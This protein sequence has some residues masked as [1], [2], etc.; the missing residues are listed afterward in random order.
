MADL[1]AKLEQAV[2]AVDTRRSGGRISSISGL[3]VRAELPL[4]RV[5]ELCELYEPGK[6]TIGFAEVVGIDGDVALLSLHGE[7]RGLSMR[8]EVVPSGREPSIEV[9][10]FLIGAII[11]AHGHIVRR[12]FGTS[13]LSSRSFRSLYGS[14]VDPL[15]RK[16]ISRTFVTGV[17][18]IDAML[19]CGEGQRVGIFGPPGAGKSTLISEIIQ[20]TQADVIVC[21]LVGER[22][23][24]VGEF[25]QH[26]MPDAQPSKMVLVSATSDRP[27]L[28]RYKAVL[29]ATAI[30]E[31]FRD[32]GK[33]VL[34]VID[35]VTRVARAMREIGL[36]SGEPPVRRGFPPSVFAALPQIFERTG[37]GVSGSITAFY[38]VLVEGADN[39]DPIAEESRSLL[40]GHIV[41][42]E[43][44]ARS[45]Q[46][47]AI[48][49]LQSRSRLMSA[50]TSTRHQTAANRIR[51][52]MSTYSDVELLIRVGEYR[53]GND[54]DVDEAVAKRDA[55]N[56]M[57]YDGKGG[58]RSFE[59]IVDAVEGLAQ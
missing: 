15:S 27:A 47:P 24:E 53:Q 26:N 4:V 22:G 37:N 9:G 23:R 10:D 44:I 51:S 57:L 12:A 2:S 40:D 43:R 41:L 18:A 36:A 16:P 8:T 21:A 35:S 50:V 48:D 42:S 29:T 3:L 54:P 14:P 25:V 28:E 33:S 19:T 6:G 1:L 46:F 55:I 59:Q 34:L 58:T 38:S 20:N 39:E 5:G 56:A 11:D 45:G 7:T 13:G 31:H 32:E 30:A 49:I 17:T 52:L